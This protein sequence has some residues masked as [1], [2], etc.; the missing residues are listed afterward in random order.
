LDWCG[1]FW[2]DLK[3]EVEEIDAEMYLGRH[4]RGATI[5][6]ELKS[7]PELLCLENNPGGHMCLDDP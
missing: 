3:S 1:A 6:I 5:D 7:I 4:I 2:V